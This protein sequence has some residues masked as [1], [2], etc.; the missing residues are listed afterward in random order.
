LLF[1]QYKSHSN[2]K[3]TKYYSK[4]TSK[5]GPDYKVLYPNQYVII[6]MFYF[7]FFAPS[8]DEESSQ[9]F[10]PFVNVSITSK[11]YCSFIIKIENFAVTQIKCY[12]FWLWYITVSITGFLDFVLHPVLCFRNWISFHSLVKMSGVPTQLGLL[13]RSNLSHSIWWLRLARHI[14]FNGEMRNFILPV[15]KSKASLC[16]YPIMI[17]CECLCCVAG[18]SPWITWELNVCLSR[19]GWGPTECSPVV[20]LTPFPC[21]SPRQK[22]PHY[23]SK[24]SQYQQLVYRTK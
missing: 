7:D 20:R 6:L 5:G 8:S 18:C 24:F 3:L 23:P 1:C 11:V 16:H 14:P 10:V 17:Y 22:R 19:F 15:N 13:E 2:I 4:S 21:V 9:I 12:G